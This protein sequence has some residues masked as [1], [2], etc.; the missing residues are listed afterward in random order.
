MNSVSYFKM[1]PLQ[2]HEFDIVAKRLEHKAHC[3]C[4][5]QISTSP[6]NK[7]P[8]SQQQTYQIFQLKHTEV[9][10]SKDPQGSLPSFRAIIPDFM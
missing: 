4:T 8:L 2:P 5:D 6:T 9:T 3:E 7:N 1:E 10:F